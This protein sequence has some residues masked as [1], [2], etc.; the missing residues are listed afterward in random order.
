MELG[1]ATARPRFGWRMESA[2]G[3][4][5][6]HAY[7]LV[8]TTGGRPVWESGRVEAPDG[9]GV[10]YAGPELASRTR[11]EWRVRSWLHGRPTPSA[12]AAAAFETSL[13]RTADWRARWVVPDQ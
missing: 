10:E 9:A 1:V 12:W 3:N 13:L 7:E 11:Y 4:L 8:V 5:L 6:Q 2:A